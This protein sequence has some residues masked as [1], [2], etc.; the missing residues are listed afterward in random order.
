MTASQLA[1]LDVPIQSAENVHRA[2]IEGGI[3]SS[4]AHLLHKE[5]EK[6]HYLGFSV[7]GTIAWKANLMGLPM[8]SLYTISSTRLRKE[9]TRPDCLTRT[10]YGKSDT[11]PAKSRLV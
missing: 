2:F 8:K 11:N 9:I 6:S 1:N 5:K 7:G 10:L 3:E 4:A